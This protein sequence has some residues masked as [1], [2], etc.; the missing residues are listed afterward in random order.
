MARV[1]T[2][3]RITVAGLCVLALSGCVFSDVRYLAS[4]S[5]AG[6]DNQSPGGIAV[7]DWLVTRLRTTTVGPVAGR[8]GAAAYQQ[9]F[10]R[11][12]NVLGLIPGTRHPDEYVMLGAHY[13]HLAS[14]GTV[15]GDSI[16]NG[17]TDNAT[18]TAL[19]L[20][21]ARRFAAHPPDR[22]VVFALWDAEEDGLVGSRHYVE[23]PVV[24]L[25]RTVA[26]LNLD[27]LG[28]NLLPTLRTTTFA[29]GAE[30]GGRALLDAVDAAYRRSGLLG[31]QLS[32]VFGMYRSDYAPFL[33]AQVPSVYFSDST[34]P[35][36]HTPEDDERAVDWVK[37]NRET[38]V[39]WRTATAL[40]GPARE[41]RPLV[42]PEWETRPLTTYADA[43]RL[44]AVVDRSLPDWDRYPQAMIDAA[45][46]HIANADRIIADG[47]DAYDAADEQQ[48]L[49]AALTFVDMMTYGDC[50]PFLPRAL[51]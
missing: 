1:R 49:A 31:E 10:P 43:V 2:V 46:V 15:D 37:L 45:L 21:M 30:T 38:R 23:N 25:A 12:T 11:G 33:D 35:C 8:T 24:P 39:L 44:R 4:D 47:P 36:Y 20:E 18:G 6:R 27:L 32:A 9:P 17:A 42:T 7:R 26:Y 3:L 48:L 22:S 28:S 14:C 51:P 13:D 50:D 34:G 40:A 16:C 5:L 29:I 19:V 41:G